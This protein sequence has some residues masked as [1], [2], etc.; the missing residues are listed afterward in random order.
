MV[1]ILLVSFW[2]NYYNDLALSEISSLFW[3]VISFI[4]LCL[5]YSFSLASIYFLIHRNVLLL[6]ILPQNTE[7]SFSICSKKTHHNISVYM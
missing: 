5:L 2:Q 1:E 6:V 7:H 4:F 3:A